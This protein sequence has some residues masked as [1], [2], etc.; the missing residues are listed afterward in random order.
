M[1]I[2]NGELLNLLIE[3]SFQALITFDK[4]LQ[5]QQ[6][7]ARY[8][9]CVFVLVA[10]NNTYADLTL[11]SSLVLTR[12]EDS[13]LPAGPIIITNSPAAANIGF[14]QAGLKNIG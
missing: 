5:H 2:K 9:I 10:K 1:V 14:A 3:N 7:F 6:N 13:K 8:S 12:L 4:D 11:L